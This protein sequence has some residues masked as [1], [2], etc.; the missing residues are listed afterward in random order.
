[1]TNSS[2]TT[3]DVALTTNPVCT[4]NCSIV[5]PL[6]LSDHFSLFASID[7]LGPRPKPINQ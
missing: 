6:G 7:L 3:I 1:M 2:E 4:N 5:S